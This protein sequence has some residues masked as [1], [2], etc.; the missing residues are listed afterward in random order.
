MEENDQQ[1][2]IYTYYQQTHKS[3]NT[4]TETNRQIQKEGCTESPETRKTV[5]RKQSTEEKGKMITPT[6]NGNRNALHEIT[7]IKIEL[8]S[9]GIQA[10]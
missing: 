2:D 9:E 1:R 5:L 7:G 6:Q 3:R 8:K 10:R 4:Q